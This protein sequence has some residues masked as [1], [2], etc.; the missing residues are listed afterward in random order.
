MQSKFSPE[1][2]APCGEKMH[3]P[4][5]SIPPATLKDSGNKLSP[6]TN[7]TT[8]K[9]TMMFGRNIKNIMNI[10]RNA[11]QLLGLVNKFEV[12]YEKQIKCMLN[13]IRTKKGAPASPFPE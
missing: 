3:V 9:L 5:T 6:F 11:M 12:M 13:S 8:I 1:N 10:G 7:M 4:Q 2:R